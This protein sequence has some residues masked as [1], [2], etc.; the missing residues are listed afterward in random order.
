M[1]EGLKLYRT[2]SKS[3]EPFKTLSKE[4]KYGDY[5]ET[6]KHNEITEMTAQDFQIT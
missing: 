4:S 5:S 2:F 1:S 6:N 3:M